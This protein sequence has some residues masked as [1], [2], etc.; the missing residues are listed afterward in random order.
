MTI[1]KRENENEINR[2][3]FSH[4][5][6]IARRSGINPT[7]ATIVLKQLLPR[8]VYKLLLCRLLRSCWPVS[9][10][11][12]WKNEPLC[13]TLWECQIV[14]CHLCTSNLQGKGRQLG[15][16]VIMT[17]SKMLLWQLVLSECTVIV[18]TCVLSCM[19]I[20][21]VTVSTTSAQ[22]YFIVYLFVVLSWH[23]YFVVFVSVCG[24]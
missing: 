19:N 2:E 13:V 15:D 23:F 8:V 11:W 5:F 17:K 6:T 7:V 20:Y 22:S 18:I 24:F 21:A 4:L 9:E 3:R 10:A 16:G 14:M 1:N 12:C